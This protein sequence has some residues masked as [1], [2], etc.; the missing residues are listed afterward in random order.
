ML[1]IY[2]IAA[3]MLFVARYLHGLGY[4]EIDLS[5]S[6]HVEQRPNAPA[7]VQSGTVSVLYALSLAKHDHMLL[8][9]IIERLRHQMT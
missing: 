9:P 8:K 3:S 5:S 7:R 4:D 2:S 6:K 1:V